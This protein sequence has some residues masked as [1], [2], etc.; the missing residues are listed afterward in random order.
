ME[1]FIRANLPVV[2]VPSIPDI[3]LHKAGPKSGLW[4]LAERDSEFGSPYWTHWWGGGVALARYILERTET[5]AGRRVLDLGA[6]SG[7][8]GI[9]AA[10]AGAREVI[11]ADIDRYAVAALGLN[12]ALNGVR[13]TALLADATAFPPPAVDV[14]AVGDLFYEHELA[15]RVTVFLDR[16]LDLGMAVLIGDPWRAYLPRARLRLL[17]EY[18]VSDFG[19]AGSDVTTPGGVFAFEASGR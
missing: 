5:V 17:A 9:A 3:R 6:G 10:K 18:P 12:A 13:L 11:A 7:L 14:V 4:R 1:D 15:A 2:A 19:A 8:V 16:C